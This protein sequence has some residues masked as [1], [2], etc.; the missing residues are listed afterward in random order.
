MA[1]APQL[2][3]VLEHL[4]Q[5]SLHP[6]HL[7]LTGDLAEEPL[8]LTYDIIGRRIQRLA[9]PTDCLPGNHDDPQVMHQT[10]PALG[11]GMSRVIHQDQWRILMLDSTMPGS[12]KGN[13]GLL[14]LEWLS[15]T[16]QEFT[17]YWIAIALHH[18][19]VSVGSLWMEGMRLKDHAAFLAMLSQHDNIRACVFGHVHQEFDATIEGVRFLGCPSTCVQFT[20]GAKDLSTNDDAPGYRVLDLFENGDIET[21]VIR[22][23]A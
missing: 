22:V 19:P 14:E 20:P 13:L 6:H 23:K 2:D 9:C 21:R 5:Q 7:I 8:P 15:E 17:S 4:E 12:S 11:L 10:L 18:P 16:L 3:K 1:T